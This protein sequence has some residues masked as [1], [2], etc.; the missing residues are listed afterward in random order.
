LNV[1]A[2]RRRPRRGEGQDVRSNPSGRAKNLRP[3]SHGW[4]FFYG[5]NCTPT[6]TKYL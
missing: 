1:A 2:K 6:N 5:S 3:S 4:P